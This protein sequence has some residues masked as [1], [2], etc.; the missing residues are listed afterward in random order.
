MQLVVG[1][2]LDPSFQ[3]F[4]LLSGEF[5][6]RVGRWHESIRI[7]R[8]DPLDELALGDIAWNEGGRGEGLLPDIQTQI[9]LAMQWVRAVAV[10]AIFGKDWTDVSIEFD[11]RWLLAYGV[12][13]QYR[14]H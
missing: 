12:M 11:G 9:G 1:A 6:I 3:K 14:S 13:H 10:Q 5:P 8:L 4:F 7:G 2:L